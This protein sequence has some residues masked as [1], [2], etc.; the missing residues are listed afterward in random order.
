MFLSAKNP[1]DR[2]DFLL[3]FPLSASDFH[4]QDSELDNANSGE[5]LRLE[6]RQLG[7]HHGPYQVPNHVKLEIGDIETDT[8]RVDNIGHIDPKVS[9]SVFK[10]S[11]TIGFG[12]QKRYQLIAKSTPIRTAKII[13]LWKLIQFLPSYNFIE[14]IIIHIKHIWHYNNLKFILIRYQVL[15]SV[16]IGID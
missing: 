9:V 13:S 16:D 3:V 6:Q 14:R 11:V 12:I 7:G 8:D 10:W 1:A 2:H 4:I 5:V 15:V